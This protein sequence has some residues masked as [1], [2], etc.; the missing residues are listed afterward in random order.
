MAKPDGTRGRHSPPRIEPDERD[1]ADLPVEE[2]PAVDRGERLD[3]GKT[4]ARG[5]HETGRVPG[6]E[7]S[8]EP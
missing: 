1:D 5:G 7:E 2:E 4:I 6:A 8:K 3:A